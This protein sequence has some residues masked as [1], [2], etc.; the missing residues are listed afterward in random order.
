[1]SEKSV[2]VI[3]PNYNGKNLLEQNLP[4]VIE[5][6]DNSG[7]DYEIIVVDDHSRDDS[8]AFL[9]ERYPSIRVVE[10]ETNEGFSVACNKGIHA[11]VNDLIL[12]LNTDIQLTP[13]YFDGMFKYFEAPDTFGVMGQ[14][15]GIK[16]EIQDVAR[17]FT[18]RGTKI[19]ANTFFYVDDSDFW[20]P[21]AYLSGAN[22]L[23]DSRKLK[24][25]GGFDEVFSPFYYEDFELG[26]RAW[27]LGWKCYYHHANFCIHEHSATTK[28]YRTRNWVKAIFFRNRFAVHGI[29]LS[30]FGRLFFYIQL[31]VSMLFLAVGF[32][33]FFLKGFGMFLSKHGEIR[34][35]R[36]RMKLLMERHGSSLTVPEVMKEFDNALAGQPI[37]YL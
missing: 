35:S 17:L 22:A 7:T 37:N 12:L 18:R 26:V 19:K 8:V 24:D 30:A 29:H 34:R 16:G 32:R 33:F 25:I 6:L 28:N 1:M 13:G 11:S 23:I 4:S 9:K 14:I 31:T 15:R 21:T 3:I 2:S 5:A 10:S 20:T 36:V 27:R